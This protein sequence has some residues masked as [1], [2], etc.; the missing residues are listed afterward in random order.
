MLATTKNLCISMVHNVVDQRV[1]FRSK[2]LSNLGTNGLRGIKMMVCKISRAAPKVH[3][4]VESTY[5]ELSSNRYN[6]NFD[7]THV[8]HQLH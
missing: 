6:I 4:H 8:Y 2:G 5:L 3:S 1:S 7:E